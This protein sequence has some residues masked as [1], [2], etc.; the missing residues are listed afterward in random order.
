[1]SGKAENDRFFDHPPWESYHPYAHTHNAL[2]RRHYMDLAPGDFYGTVFREAGIPNN[3]RVLDIGCG[4]G[5]DIIKINCLVPQTKLIGLEAAFD[6]Y[7]TKD[8]L[9]HIIDN[10]DSHGVDNAEIILGD[11]HN[12]PFADNSFDVVLAASVIQESPDIT[13][14]IN[15]IHRV[16]VDGGKLIVIENMNDN[17]PLHHRYLQEMAEKLDAIAAPR[18]SS[19]FTHE[20]AMKTFKRRDDFT[21]IREV[22]QN[23]TGRKNLAIKNPE[24][25]L[26]LLLSLD[27][28]RY[29]F[30]PVVES[31]WNEARIAY[32]KNQLHRRIFDTWPEL[33]RQVQLD[34][35]RQI[36]THGAAYETIRRG[37][38]ICQAVKTAGEKKRF[39]GSTSVNESLGKI[40]GSAVFRR[41]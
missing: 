23:P 41:S 13:E 1:M 10:L 21:N 22:V 15:Q 2:I 27:T 31:D 9:T 26:S 20:I 30:R 24:E 39:S 40:I 8:K 37:A 25:I 7:T 6:T 19:R 3:A 16:L 36:R 11:M 35:R 34:V 38:V 33:R 12:L 32:E 28:Y 29:M 18:F 5:T 17:K 4:D 14:A